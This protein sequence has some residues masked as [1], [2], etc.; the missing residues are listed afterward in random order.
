MSGVRGKINAARKR[1]EIRAKRSQGKYDRKRMAGVHRSGTD[2][3]L[4]RRP[5]QCAEKASIRLRLHPPYLAA[6]DG[7]TSALR[8]ALG[9]A[10]RQWAGVGAAPGTSPP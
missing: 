9:R 4:P 1:R 10:L 6:A 8:R 2:A 7:E 3:L 5:S